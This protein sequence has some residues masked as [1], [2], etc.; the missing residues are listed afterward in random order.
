MPRERALT[1]KRAVK[2]FDAHSTAA[3][4][5]DF[6]ANVVAAMDTRRPAPGAVRTCDLK[7]TSPLFPE[8]VKTDIAPTEPMPEVS[9][10]ALMSFTPAGFLAITIRQM[11]VIHD[12]SR[13]VETRF[14]VERP[15]T[16]E[17][18]ATLPP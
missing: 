16:C 5:T 3:G 17:V 6:V 14:V 18:V 7:R 11:S 1:V 10:L 13:M 12:S 8:L 15:A 2:D 9:L 4:C